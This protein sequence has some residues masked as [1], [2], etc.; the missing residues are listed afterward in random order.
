MQRPAAHP[1]E[2]GPAL[3]LNLKVKRKH[4]QIAAAR[5]GER[6]GKPPEKIGFSRVF[7]L[8]DREPLFDA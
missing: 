4:L 5:Q 1:P 7:V 3:R 2:A 6:G 8:I